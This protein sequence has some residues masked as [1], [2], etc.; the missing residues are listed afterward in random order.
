MT[1]DLDT[2]ITGVVRMRDSL[3][4]Q[5]VAFDV[6]AA[7]I[8]RSR[9]ETEAAIRELNGYIGARDARKTS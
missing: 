6:A 1:E 5:L 3:E 8:E 7:S 4:N 2:T 9:R